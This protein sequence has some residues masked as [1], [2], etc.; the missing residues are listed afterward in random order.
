MAII[1]AHRIRRYNNTSFS[2]HLENVRDV[3]KPTVANV[4]DIR[5]VRHSDLHARRLS[6]EMV[7]THPTRQF[8]AAAKLVMRL[9]RRRVTLQNTETCVYTKSPPTN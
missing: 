5:A 8:K 3:H 9:W 4:M 1:S 2:R 6:P 7:R